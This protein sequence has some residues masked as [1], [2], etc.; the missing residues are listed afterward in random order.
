MDNGLTGKLAL[1][2]GDSRGLG[3]AITRRRAEAGADVAIN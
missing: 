1:V 2:T 3:R